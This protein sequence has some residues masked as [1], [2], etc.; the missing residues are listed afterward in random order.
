MR[1]PD[2]RAATQLLFTGLFLLVA[3]GCASTVSI[4]ERHWGSIERNAQL[5]L[6]LEPN[7][8]W[9]LCFNELV[10]YGPDS[11]E[12]LLSRP[13]MNRRAAPDDLRAMLTT[14]LL[15]LLADSRTAP[16]LSVNCYETT[17]DLL[18]FQPKVLGRPLGE[19]RIPT[20]RIPSVWHDLYPVDFN[21]LLAQAIDVESDRRIMKLWWRARDGDFARYCADRLLQPSEDYLW[22][23]LSRRYAD[24][25]T[26][27]VRPAVFLCGHT[28]ANT[29]LM[30]GSSFD[31][32]LV[33]AA[34][35]WLGSSENSDVSGRLISLVGHPSDVVSYNA[36]FAL[37]FQRDPRI[38]AVIERYNN[39]D[40]VPLPERPRIW[41]DI[42]PNAG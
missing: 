27:D 1:I 18:Y 30:R 5:L 6:N 23:V 10:K 8:N 32:N 39:A 14:S 16:R 9:T 42:K 26:Y 40:A 31:Y 24:V 28:P 4:P 37:R 13:E 29:T 35:V 11:V 22:D 3:S 38:R 12:Y 19:V 34:C 20:K 25:W 36:R 41:S 21:H 7:A 2:M 15:R 33:R 17:L